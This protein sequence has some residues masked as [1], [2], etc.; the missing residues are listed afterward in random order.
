M[1][2]RSLSGGGYLPPEPP[3]KCIRRRAFRGVR[4]GGSPPREAESAIKCPK[5]LETAGTRWNPLE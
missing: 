2:L 1:F 3:E 4:G 5:Q